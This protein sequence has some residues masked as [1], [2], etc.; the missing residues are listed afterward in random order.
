MTKVLVI[1]DEE[2]LRESILNILNTR[3]LSALGAEDGRKGLELAKEWVP[4]LILS[5]VRMPELNGYEVLNA[6]QQEP[7]TATIPF[8]FLTAENKENVLLQGQALRAVGYLAKPFST[9]ELLEAISQ[10]LEKR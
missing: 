2:I 8:L 4:D 9:A 7:L 1:E 10:V 5:D 3:G 6:L